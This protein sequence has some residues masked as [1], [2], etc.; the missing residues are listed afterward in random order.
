MLEPS[1]DITEIAKAIFTLLERDAGELDV[2]RVFYGDQNKVPGARTVCVEPGTL[3]RNLAGG[4]SSN[5]TDNLA[6][7]YVLIYVQRVDNVDAITEEGDRLGTA[8][9]NKLHENGKLDGLVVSSYV[10]LS[11][12]G[13]T[14]RLQGQLWR[15]V[16]LTWQGLNKTYLITPGA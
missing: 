6:V 10:T 7:V 3:A 11:E 1:H 2:G 14:P 5:R 8:V 16:R 9:M 12:Y 4:G 15:T 13:Y